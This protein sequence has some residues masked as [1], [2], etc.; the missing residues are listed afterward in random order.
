MDTRFGQADQ[1]LLSVLLMNS[2]YLNNVGPKYLYATVRTEMDY[3][4]IFQS[5]LIILHVFYAINKQLVRLVQLACEMLKSSDQ[6]LP[7]RK[8]CETLYKTD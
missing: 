3:K 4:Y 1:N 8:C 6:I 2:L 7:I 5:V